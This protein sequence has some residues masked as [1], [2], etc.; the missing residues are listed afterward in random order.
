[1]KGES[2]FYNDMFVFS[3]MWLLRMSEVFDQQYV[4]EHL[5]TKGSCPEINTKIFAT[6]SKTVVMLI[7]DLACRIALFS[8]VETGSLLSDRDCI[9]RR[10][11]HSL[12]TVII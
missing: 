11:Y 1:V 4:T 3:Y 7:R 12:V 10:T 9:I 2:F 5:H 8:S 6:M